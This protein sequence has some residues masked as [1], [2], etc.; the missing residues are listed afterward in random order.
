MHR[1]HLKINYLLK[2]EINELYLMN[3][4]R[5]FAIS[6]IVVF[7]PIFLLIKG[8][9]LADIGLFYLIRALTGILFCYTALKYAAKKG[10]KHSLLLSIP[11]MTIFFI[12]LYNID[13]LR[14]YM[15]DMT[16]LLC[17]AVLEALAS[18]YYY[19]GFHVEFA[20]LSEEKKSMKQLGFIQALSMIASVLGPL[21]GAL[22]ITFASFNVLFLIVVG[23]LIISL[24]PL[25]MSGEY[26]EPFHFN[27]KQA[28]SVKQKERSAPFFA[29]GFHTMAAGIFWPMFMFLIAISIN[30]IGGIYA[31]SNLVLVLFTLYLA[32]K[33]T[34]KNKHRILKIGTALHA[35]TLI[36]RTLLKTVALIVLV[37]GFGALTWTMVHIPFYST[38]YNNS[39]K[40]GIA[41]MIFFREIYLH[42]GRVLSCLLF[43]AILHFLTPT[44]ALVTAI[45]IGAVVMLFMARI[46]EEAAA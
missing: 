36:I 46:K 28:L 23:L 38:F 19:M 8:Y 4:I 13:F 29:E 12:S 43:L 21:F 40:T 11:F 32:K 15:G 10:V 22:V 3:A 27:L 26:H 33:A 18:A 1:L 25:F 45:I 2:K 7:I 20:K 5:T 34:E 37:Q 39:K 6:T 41:N 24:V 17:V 31:V 16:V 44:T 14:T 30:S 42:A 35:L 9:G